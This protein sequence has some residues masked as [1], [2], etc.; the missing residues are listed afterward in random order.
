MDS[1]FF[2][3]V[4]CV[5]TNVDSKIM[6]KIV[7]FDVLKDIIQC[8]NMELFCTILRLAVP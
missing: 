8:S 7:K 1:L 3:V 4:D 6:E 5:S 2:D